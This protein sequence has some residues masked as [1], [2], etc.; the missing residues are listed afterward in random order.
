MRFMIKIKIFFLFIIW[1][2]CYGVL[3]HKKVLTKKQFTIN[4]EEDLVFYFDFNYKI[5]SKSS[6]RQDGITTNSIYLGVDST[7]VIF[8]VSYS[9]NVNE[10]TCCYFDSFQNRLAKKTFL[11]G[12]IIQNPDSN[13]IRIEQNYKIDSFCFYRV[14]YPNLKTQLHGSN[15]KYDMDISIV[16]DTNEMY[17][18]SLKSIRTK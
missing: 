10:D 18:T 16:N 15:S 4:L 17:F 13:L 2:S 5:I 12:L 6:F 11:N 3:D 8:Y 14:W 1:S 7:E 9:K